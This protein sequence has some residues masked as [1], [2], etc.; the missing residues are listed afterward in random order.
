ML[1]PLYYICFFRNYIY[2]QAGTELGLGW[3][4]LQ[5]SPF[6]PYIVILKCNLTMISFSLVGLYS[7]TQ[8]PLQL[9]QVQIS[10]FPLFLSLI[11]YFSNSSVSSFSPIGFFLAGV[12]IKISLG[13]Y[14]T[15][16]DDNNI[17]F[18]FYIIKIFLFF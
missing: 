12:N 14:S 17:L 15:F 18:Y 5:P 8:V 9:S 7:R 2:I 11:L 4:L 6:F 3:F 1:P 13:I 10:G 16:L